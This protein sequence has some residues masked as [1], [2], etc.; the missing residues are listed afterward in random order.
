MKKGVKIIIVIAIIFVILFILLYRFS[1]KEARQLGLT[2]EQYVL[3]KD[4]LDAGK[5]Y[6]EAMQIAKS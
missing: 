4:A 2:D 3:Y 1:K 6:E 5:S